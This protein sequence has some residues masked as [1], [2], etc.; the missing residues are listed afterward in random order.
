MKVLESL[1]NVDKAKLIHALFT[2]EIPGFLAYTQAM[3]AFIKEH[4]DEVRKVWKNPLFGID[5]WFQLAEQADQVIRKYGRQLEKSATLFSDQLFDGY[6]ALYLHH[7]LSSYTTEGRQKD[8]KFK[9]AVDLFFN[10]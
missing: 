9:L 10:P 7:C 8:P 3:C 4:P 1:T 5:F 6:N 2:D